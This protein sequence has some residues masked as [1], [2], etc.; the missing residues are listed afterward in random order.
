M[1]DP[2]PAVRDLLRAATERLRRD[3]SDAPAGSAET[4]YLDALVLLGLASGEPT[5]RLLA[6][7]PDPVAPDVRARFHSL[8][9]RRAAGV[10]VS[11]LRGSKEF[12]GRDFLVSPS[13]LV[14]RPETEL[15]V[16]LTLALADHRDMD[17]PQRPHGEARH[18]GRA[19][20]GSAHQAPSSDAAQPPDAAPLPG[21]RPLHVHD[22]CTGS[23]CVAVT[24]AAERPGLLVSVSDV[25]E[26]ALAVARENATR[27]APGR[28]SFWRSNLLSALG[29]ECDR[30]GLPAPAIIT[31]NPPYLTDEEYERLRRAGWPEPE[32][33]LRAGPDGLALVRT[34]ARQ[35][36][37]VLAPGSYLVMEVGA[38]QG[39]SSARILRD[40]GFGE[41][42]VHKDYAGRDRVVV[43][44]R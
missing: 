34:L 35:A 5:E 12:Y 21:A 23:G 38:E 15:L 25:D 2:D 8:L 11:Y 41:A 20:R 4:P 26:A 39:D 30:L 9:D 3:L 16:E 27:I 43:G 44:R 7:L 6:S 14:P 31:A 22:A 24:L 40:A 17:G 37:T 36:V 18:G 10:P 29:P 42:R 19:P 1:A 33:A 13:V 28:I 32:R